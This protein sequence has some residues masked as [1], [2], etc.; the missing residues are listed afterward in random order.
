LFSKAALKCPFPTH[1]LAMADPKQQYGKGGAVPSVH[2][3]AP[4]PMPRN[5][6]AEFPPHLVSYPPSLPLF[7]DT[8]SNLFITET[9]AAFERDNSERTWYWKRRRTFDDLFLAPPR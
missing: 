8:W 1:P 7:L 3:P 6:P 9:N 5:G 2:A 4:V